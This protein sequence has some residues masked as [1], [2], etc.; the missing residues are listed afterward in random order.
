MTT[1]IDILNEFTKEKIIA[2]VREKGYSCASVAETCF[3][4]TGRLLARS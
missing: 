4:S 2:F 1:G 3:S